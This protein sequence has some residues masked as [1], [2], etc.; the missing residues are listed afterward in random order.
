M[1]RPAV[2]HRANAEAK[3]I[4]PRHG[5]RRASL[6]SIHPMSFSKLREHAEPQRERLCIGRKLRR[7]PANGCV[8][9][10]EFG[11]GID[12]DYLSPD[13]EESEPARLARQNP[14]LVTIAKVRRGGLGS[15]V[16]IGR[17]HR[18]GVH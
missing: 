2:A 7:L 12:Q 15:E 1:P 16:G 17:M 9:H 10:D 13:S 6:C 18:R 8:H 5:K 11:G 14:D 3:P 4:T